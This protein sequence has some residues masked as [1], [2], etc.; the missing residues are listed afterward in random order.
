M[1]SAS[2]GELRLPKA[3]GLGGAA[4]DQRDGLQGLD[5][6]A[7][8]DRAFDVTEPKQNAPVSIGDGDGA[9]VAALH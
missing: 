5:G 6:R 8:I 1:R 9:A 7:R 4:F 2:D 3:E